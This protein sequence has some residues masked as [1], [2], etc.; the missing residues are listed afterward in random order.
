MNLIDKFKIAKLARKLKSTG[1]LK[2]DR[3]YIMYKS[4]SNYSNYTC[5]ET[6]NI[7]KII[8]LLTKLSTAN[9]SFRANLAILN[10]CYFL[11]FY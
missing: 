11:F 7:S 4:Y 6:A 2:A 1:S 10:F 9:L 3:I 8:S 5:I